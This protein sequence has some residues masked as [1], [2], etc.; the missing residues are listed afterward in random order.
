LTTKE[1]FIFL[2]CHRYIK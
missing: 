2:G 1:S